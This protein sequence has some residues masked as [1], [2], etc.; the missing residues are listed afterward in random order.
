MSESFRQNNSLEDYFST[1]EA[2]IKVYP[3]EGRFHFHLII[4]LQRNGRIE[5]AI[6]CANRASDFLPDNYTFT[7]LKYLLIPSIYHEENEIGFYRQRF[8]DGLQTL[9]QETS[10]ETSAEKQE[11]FTAIAIIRLLFI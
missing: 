8:T 7:L 2:G 9:I 4:D 10:L 11:A 6:A 1:L 5:S 3:Q